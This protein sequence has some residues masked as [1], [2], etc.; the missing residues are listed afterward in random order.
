[1]KKFQFILITLLPFIALGQAVKNSPV[2][3]TAIKSINS[4][5]T[6]YKEKHIVEKSY[7]QFDKPYYA[8][9]D[10]IY[11]KAYVT[12]GAEH[13]LSALSGI[14]YVDLISPDNRISRSIKLQMLAGVA[15]GD[16]ALADTLKGGNYRVR[17]YTNWMRNDDEAAFFEQTIPI[18]GNTI[19]GITESGMPAKKNAKVPGGVN[20]ID[21]QFLPEGDG[22]V[23]GNYS[24]MAFKAIGP[25]GL[26]T[27][28]K[29]TVT[30]DGGNVVTT[31]ASA[32]LG[33]GSFNIVPQVGKS[34]KANL[35]FANGITNTVELPKATA[36]G[37]TFSLNNTNA[38]TIRIRV[39]A[40]TASSLDKLSIVAQAGGVI[41]YAAEN[42]QPGSKFFSAVIAKSKFPTGVIQFTL[43]NDAGEPLNERLAFI[44]HKDELKFKLNTK[45]SYVP[46]EKVKIDLNANNSADKPVTGSFSVAVTDETI[47]P[48]DT[49]NENTILTNLLLTSDLKGV[50]EQ[51][52]YYFAKI[53]EKTQ[54]DL[55]LLML[56]QGYRH[57]EWKQVL[58]GKEPIIKYQPE[59]DL[60]IS[61]RV[62]KQGKPVLN[63]K[64]T[65]FTNK[66]GAFMLDT[67]TDKNGRFAFSHLLFEDST[68]FVVQSKVTKG[69]DAL[70][71]DLDTVLSPKLTIENNIHLKTTDTI[72]DNSAYAI[73][74]KQFLF[75]QQKYGINKHPLILRE[76]HIRAK[77]EQVVP[78]S[79]NLNGPGNAKYVLTSADLER[80]M[81]NKLSD[82]LQGVFGLKFIHGIPTQAVVIDGDFVDP[83]MFDELH[84]DDIEGIEILDVHDGAI[85][86][87]RA[88]N[89]IL[90]VTTKRG[91]KT[92]NYYRY[93]PGVITYMPKGLY[94]AREFYSPQY[95]NPHT[96]PKMADLRSTIYW[97][98]NII[99]DKYG[100]AS[101]E[102]F[103]ADG[104][105]TYKVVI[106]GIDA[107]GNLGRQVFRY[108]V[109]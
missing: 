62:S 42:Q 21:V 78:H 2:E 23:A 25:D 26:G 44:N 94:K 83:D 16:F 102:Y 59:K 81:C 68:K 20:K 66:G 10:T 18:A 79:Q 43:F 85:Y 108:K 101:F 1:M 63:A 6:A 37:Y 70:T 73:N 11:F 82:C 40:G 29:G 106:E 54:A 98:P 76:V 33:M 24:K 14:L 22:L 56:T 69:Q 17:A 48:V 13:K 58:S 50:V 52:S 92:N 31:L 100:K 65:L 38:D 5:L 61:G 97:N 51:P 49:V 39:T 99:T 34:Y 12:I 95:D 96:N 89:G 19:K 27:D 88:A 86:G 7:L 35:M 41:Y 105:G 55:D 53:N 8:V 32:H 36:T 71:L 107:D 90:L 74:Q 67:V 28:V 77:K 75:E 47:V 30:D 80:F 103:N 9:G 4:R 3:G 60:E 57:F 87:S 84:V 72:A 109:E 93:A 64:V 46:R 45:G 91:R 104:K 15:W